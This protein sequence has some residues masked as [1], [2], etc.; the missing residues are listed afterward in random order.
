M[1]GVVFLRYLPGL[2]CK[3]SSNCPS[4]CKLGLSDKQSSEERNVAL[5]WLIPLYDSPRLHATY[6]RLKVIGA[7]HQLGSLCSVTAIRKI[8]IGN[9][10]KGCKMVVQTETFLNS[11]S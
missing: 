1:F 8:W 11:A 9:L 2:A 3:A 5:S 6:V 4:G 10:K 7:L